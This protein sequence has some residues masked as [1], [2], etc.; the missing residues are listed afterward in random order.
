MALHTL[1]NPGLA[2]VI[3]LHFP[4]GYQYIKHTMD[5]GL[6]TGRDWI[7]G[8]V[9]AVAFG[10]LLLVRSTF[11]WLVNYDSPYPFTAAEMSRGGVAARLAAR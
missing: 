5:T 10:Y 9:Y 3:L 7:L 11:G 2:S 1:Y 4:I 8:I 6:L